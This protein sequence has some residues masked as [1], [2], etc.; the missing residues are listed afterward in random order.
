[1]GLFDN[2]KNAIGNAAV[3]LKNDYEVAM[4]K[5]LNTLCEEYKQMKLMDPK[6]TSISMSINEKLNDLSDDELEDFYEV[7]KKAGSLFKE[8]PAKNIVEGVLVERNIYV[9]M[10]DGTVCRNGLFR[11]KRR[12]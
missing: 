9:R 11:R 4:T 8:H 6:R 10:E 7:I 3:E 12:K 1:M 2:I 5:D